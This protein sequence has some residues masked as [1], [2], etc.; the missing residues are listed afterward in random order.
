MAEITR[1]LRSVE[2]GDSKASD[3]LLALVYDEL[4]ALAARKMAHEPSG[5]TLQATALVHEAWLRLGGDQQPTWRNRRQFFAAAAEAMR[6][7]LVD[8]ARR[9]MRQRHG[10]G[11]RRVDTDALRVPAGMR[12]DRLL[13][14]DEALELLAGEDSRKVII[15]KLR[16]FVGLSNQEIAET[17]RLSLATV[18]RDWAYA[19]AWLFEKMSNPG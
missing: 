6:R 3:D 17:L 5:Q 11:V 15:V 7:I 16:Y 18:E 10:G 12:E 4:R 14:L 8:K 2:S 13:A 9:K 19:K 1:I